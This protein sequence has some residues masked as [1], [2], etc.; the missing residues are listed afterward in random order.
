MSI[1][2]LQDYTR[3]A[4]YAKYVP[5]KNRRE[6]WKEQVDRVF[7]MHERYLKFRGVW[8]SVKEEVEFAKNKMMKK[9]VLGSQRALQF[10]GDAILLKHGRIYNCSASYVDRPRF[11]QECLYMLLLGCGTGFSVQKHHINRLPKI[12]SRNDGTSTFVVEDSIEGWSDALG[13]LM[14]SFFATDKTEFK[15]YRGKVVEFD[16]SKIRSKG[17]PISWGGKAPGPGGLRDALINIETVLNTRLLT[18]DTLRPIDAYDIIMH[19]SDAVLS[20]GVR[21]SACIC[22]FSPDDVEMTNAKTGNWFNENPQRGRSNNSALLIRST[23]TRADFAKLMESVKGFGEPGFIWSD[24]TEQLYNPCCEIGL[25]AYW[26]NDG[27][28]VWKHEAEAAWNVTENGISGWQVCNLCEIN[29]KKCNTEEKFYEVC[30]AAAIIGTIQ[31]SYH[32]IEY[33]GNVSHKIISGEALIG[34]SMTGMMDNPNIAFN[35][36]IQR[37][38][39]EE[40]KKKNIEIAALLEIN[41]A[42]RTTC[43]KPAGSTSCLLGTSSGIHPHLS[44][45]R[46]YI[47]RVQANEL[48]FPAKHFQK[49]NPSAVEKSVWNRS[50]RDLVL[51]FLCELSEYAKNK[52]SM[53][54]VE[55]LDKVKLTQQNWVE[56]GTNHDISK[57]SWNRHNVSNTISIKDSEWVEVEQYIWDNRQ[58]FAGIS[59]LPANGDKDYPQLPFTSVLD[60]KEIIKEYGM[61]SMF[62]SGLIVD[63]LRLFDDNLWKACDIV[64]GNTPMVEVTS[65]QTDW[66]R[67]VEQFANRYTN[68]D[69]RKTT[70]LMKDVSN[71]K[72]WCDLKREYKTVDWDNVVETDDYVMEANEMAGSA[73][74]GGQCEM[75]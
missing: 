18:S 64:L 48:E 44:T 68:G 69:V 55:L 52:N 2:A 23:A 65:E 62:A 57:Q 22:L 53:T 63:G 8:D 36:E 51:S 4:K 21:R 60:E 9:Y 15:Q 20:G 35:P 17:S 31:A 54:A 61:G 10:G 12:A 45:T 73:C 70:Y 25:H 71:W 58:W 75:K 41:P 30:R 33:L 19:A 16:F 66:L 49:I 37:K 32:H 13:V 1:E 6:T 34:V 43:V 42:V 46:R 74:S 11:F 24:N 7:D 67:R 56:Y 5:S 38:G 40:I 29:V 26:Q 59:L 28:K 72:T 27:T 14:S 47:R 50:G 3:Y 39:A